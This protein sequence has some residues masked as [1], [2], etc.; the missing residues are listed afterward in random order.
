M[1]LT[2]SARAKRDVREIGAYIAKDNRTAAVAVVKRVAATAASLLDYPLMGHA[3]RVPDT[4][5]ILVTG[6]PYIIVY[7]ADTRA[8]RIAAVMHS[9]RAWPDAF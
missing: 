1:T 4:R 3:G 7:R 9:S 5:E 8:V 6:T 2:W